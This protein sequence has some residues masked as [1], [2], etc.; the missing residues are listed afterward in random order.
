MKVQIVTRKNVVGKPLLTTMRSDVCFTPESARETLLNHFLTCS[1]Y[2]DI[3]DLSFTVEISN[4][5]WIGF[6]PVKYRLHSNMCRFGICST[7][8][9]SFSAY[10]NIID[11]LQCLNDE[12]HAFA[13][14]KKQV[15]LLKG[16]EV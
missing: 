5:T 12:K 13:F 8:G 16:I 9:P 15:E 14:A 6:Y 10:A 11:L 2:G 7:C 3:D 4:G 1:R